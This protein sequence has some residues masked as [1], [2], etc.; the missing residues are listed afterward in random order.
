[1]MKLKA[2]IR[3]NLALFVLFVMTRIVLPIQKSFHRFRREYAHKIIPMLFKW[4][5]NSDL[6]LIKHN[7]H[8]PIEE[9]R[10][11]YGDLEERY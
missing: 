6:W 4:A 11:D 10:Y 9:G 7:F 5:Y 2:A 3:V 1:M 8:F